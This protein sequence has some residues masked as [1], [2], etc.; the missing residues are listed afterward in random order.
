MSLSPNEIRDRALNFAHEWQGERREK[1]EA[2]TFW[3]GFFNVF[4]VNRRR[5]AFLFDLY[6]KYTTLLPA[7]E[8]PKRVRSARKTQS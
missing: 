6:Q 4:G 3:N 8:K 5:V 2:Q 7:A 1:A